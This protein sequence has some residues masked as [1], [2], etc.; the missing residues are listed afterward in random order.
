MSRPNLTSHTV[1]VVLSKMSS[2]SAQLL[3]DTP[4]TTVLQVASD[5]DGEGIFVASDYATHL[6]TVMLT[7]F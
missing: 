4:L 5:N 7:R 6:I 3:K 2:S 1:L